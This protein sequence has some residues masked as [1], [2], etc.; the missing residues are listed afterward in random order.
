SHDGHYHGYGGSVGIYF[1]GP[2]YWGYPYYGYPYGYPYYGYSYYG[3][4]Y[5]YPAYPYYGGSTVTYDDP[6]PPVSGAPSGSWSP[7]ANEAHEAPPA[8]RPPVQFRYYCP[9]S[10]AYYPDVRTCPKGWVQQPQT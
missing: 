5:G 10:S 9:D 2:W 6:A 4:P 8:T 3:Y 7:P 1:G